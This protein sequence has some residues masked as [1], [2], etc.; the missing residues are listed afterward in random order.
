M[1]FVLED[2]VHDGSMKEDEKRHAD[3]DSEKE[4]RLNT[5]QVRWK[6]SSTSIPSVAWRLPWCRAQTL[7]VELAETLEAV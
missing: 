5:V 4:W 7:L 6:V 3:D 2:H 1:N